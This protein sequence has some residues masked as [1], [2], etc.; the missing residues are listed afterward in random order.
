MVA[1]MRT[2][3]KAFVLMF[4]VGVLGPGAAG[5]ETRDVSIRVLA[6]EETR[7]ISGWQ[8][9]ISSLIGA[10]SSDFERLFGIRLVIG[11]YA[12]WASDDSLQTLDLLL[13]AL[14]AQAEKRGCDTLLA[15]TAQ[16]NLNSGLSGITLFKEGIL[17]ATLTDD[18]PGLERILKHEWGHMFG[19]AHIEDSESVMGFFIK[20]TG[21]D[22]LNARAVKI[23]K[24]RAFDGIDFPIRKS[25]RKAAI[26]VY[27]EICDFNEKAPARPSAPSLATVLKNAGVTVR[28]ELQG[29]AGEGGRK[30]SFFLDDAY[31]LLAQIHLEEKEYGDALAACHEALK[32]NPENL[33]TKNLEGII[34][35]RQGRVEDAI[36][37]YRKILEARPRSARFLYNLGIALARTGETEGAMDCYRRALRIKPNFVEAY[38]N[39]GELDL[40]AGRLGEAEAAFAKAVSLNAS[41]A[42]GHSNLAE[43][44]ARKNEY[45]KSQAEVTL[46]LRLNPDLPGPHNVRG[47]L[48]HRQSRASEAVTE[49]LKAI[50][51]DPA[52]EKAYYNLG[53]CRFEEGRIPEASDLFSKAIE[54]RPGFPEAHASLGYCLLMNRKTEA[55]IA[56]IQLSLKLGL[57]SAAAHLNLSYAY[58]QKN[59]A[60]A[61]IDEALRAIAIDPA[62]AMA[63][64]NLGIAY[65][66]KGETGEAVA[67]FGK[68]GELDPKYKDAF[69]NLANLL[70]RL[71]KKDEAL[72]LFLKASALDPNDGSLHN[73]IAL[74]YYEKGAYDKA[75]GH[76]QKAK[77][78]GIAVDPGFLDELRKKLKLHGLAAG[79]PVGFNPRSHQEAAEGGLLM[80]SVES[81]EGD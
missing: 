64:N 14:E 77:A 73:N 1:I 67:A 22:A 44:Y 79:G 12:G 61:A 45:G 43:V 33:E 28:Q 3:F 76:A 65:T 51:L 24:D 32:L 66:K 40:R 11:D 23:C 26:E 30:N 47:N 31:I 56:E 4:A 36:H 78:L 41:F 46:A 80:A 34:M 17:L 16:K 50:D 52:Y 57:V 54:L 81:R 71:G 8:A 68:A 72:G 39:S 6:D 5:A 42:L 18:L 59:S 62:L 15:F 53:I 19:A 75:W 29:V 60:D 63:H 13:D 27:R 70:M 25:A 48:F 7:A 9:R 37:V 35:R 58:L 2:V 38:N 21:F 74:L 69:A 20:G 10:V 55:G 49:Y